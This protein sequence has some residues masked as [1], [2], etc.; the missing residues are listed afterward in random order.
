MSGDLQGARVGFIGLGLMGRAMAEHLRDAGASLVI[1]NR[2][3]E[4]VE[5]LCRDGGMA[6]ASSSAEVAQQVG[7]GLIVLCLT[8]TSAVEAVM[9]GDDGLLAHI[10][11]GALVIDMGTTAVAATR[12]FDQE[13]Q[14]RK[15]S[16]IDAPVSGGQG[17]ARAASLSIMAGGAEA[18]FE[19]ALPLLQT[20]GKRITHMGA[21]GAGQVCKMANQMIVAQTIDAVAQALTLARANDV[22]P[23][24]VREALMGGFA[25]SRILTE[26]GK[27]MV[28]GDFEP[29]GRAVCQ[30]KDVREGRD[31]MEQSGL[32]FS[33]LRANLHNWEN[34][35]AAGDG[36]LDHSALIRLYENKIDRE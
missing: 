30:L 6:A 20:L 17:G 33:L 11:A 13:L 1:H 24:L 32:D 16:L 31:L 21:S 36:D 23:A 29:G 7:S 19:R 8:Q 26:H 10:E 4:V 34:M 15:S 27:R 18:D 5:E 2:S 12:L 22:D 35:I 3:R 28:E 25:D 9:T 14:S